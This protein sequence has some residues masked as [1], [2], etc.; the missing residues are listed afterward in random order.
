MSLGTSVALATG[1]QVYTW[2]P[3]DR[4]I[5]AKPGELALGQPASFPLHRFGGLVQS[6]LLTD[7]RAH[8]PVPDALQ[9][10]Q[11]QAEASC[12]QTAHLVEQP[13]GNHPLASPID[14]R[15][16]LAALARHT[17]L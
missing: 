6:E 2:E 16:K 17:D 4:V 10:W 15:I 7:D 13:G 1:S 11:L 14:E 9:R 8:L 12:D 3:P 5:A